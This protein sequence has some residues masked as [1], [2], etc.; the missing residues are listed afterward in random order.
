MTKEGERYEG[1]GA[2]E[3]EDQRSDAGDDAEREEAV[4]LGWVRALCTLRE[5]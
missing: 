2:E 4:R 3:P 5:A 1:E